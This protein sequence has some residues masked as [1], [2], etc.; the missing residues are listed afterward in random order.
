MY[1]ECQCEIG[2]E[3]RK[4]YGRKSLY[5]SF[6]LVTFLYG[7]PTWVSCSF[8]STE[9]CKCC[10]WRIFPII[11][12]SL[13]STRRLLSWKS[14]TSYIVARCHA[15]PGWRNVCLICLSPCRLCATVKYW[16]TFC[17]QFSIDTCFLIGGVIGY[18]MLTL[19]VPNTISVHPL[20]NK[21]RK[22]ENTLLLSTLKH[23]FTDS[24]VL[25]VYSTLRIPPRSTV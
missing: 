4:S 21:T 6:V 5:I 11:D 1:F 25:L 20:L 2:F 13:C 7:F 24:L 16:L 22:Y 3:D 17:I 18:S 23:W 12:I 14:L 9:S 19:S 15:M 8:H 10:V